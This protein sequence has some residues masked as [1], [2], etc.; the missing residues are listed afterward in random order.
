[1]SGERRCTPTGVLASVRCLEKERNGKREK[2]LGIL[3]I[4]LGVE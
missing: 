1:M 4:R 2:I 3:D